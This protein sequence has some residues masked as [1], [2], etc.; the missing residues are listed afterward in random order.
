MV[1]LAACTGLTASELS[2]LKWRYVDRE[3][4]KLYVRIPNPWAESTTIPLSPSLADVLIK[5]ERRSR[6]KR[7]DDLFLVTVS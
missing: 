6:S 7:P 5:W 1:L 4:G 3:N 2:V